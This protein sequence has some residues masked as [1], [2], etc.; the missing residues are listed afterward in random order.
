MNADDCLIVGLDDIRHD[1]RLVM[2][3]GSTT[4]S[5]QVRRPAQNKQPLRLP[6]IRIKGRPS[7][8]RLCDAISAVQRTSRCITGIQSTLT[9][10]T[11]GGKTLDWMAG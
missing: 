1:C 3:K 8:L 5:F 7:H 11:Y 6:S 9:R 4:T 2:S 10:D